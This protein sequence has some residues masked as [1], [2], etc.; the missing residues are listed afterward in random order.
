MDSAFVDREVRGLRHHLGT[1]TTA[2]VIE[3]IAPVGPASVPELNLTSPVDLALTVWPFPLKPLP[4]NILTK[5]GYKPVKGFEGRPEQRFFNADKDVR[6]L[7]VEAGSDLWTRYAVVRDFLRNSVDARAAFLGA[8]GT[9]TTTFLADAEHWWTDFYSFSPLET[10]T[11]AFRSFTHPWFFSSGWALDL[12]LGRVTRVHHDVDVVVPRTAIPAAREHLNALGWQLVLP[13]EG[14]LEPWPSESPLAPH[15]Q[16]HAHRGSSM[17]DLL[18]TEMD[19]ERWVYRREPRVTCPAHQ[20]FLQTESG[21]P[22]LAP[23]LVLLFK[24]RNTGVGKYERPQDEKDFRAVLPHLTAK[25]KNWLRGALERTD[26]TH[27][28]LERLS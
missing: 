24:S 9:V 23:E 13:L 6:L 22:L 17:M 1:L 25:Q 3:Q 12:F 14:R 19:A 11:E 27:R 7:I 26:P 18:L 28:W 8:Q 21:L 10:V 5:Q 2:G 20:A 15:I 4:L 16:I